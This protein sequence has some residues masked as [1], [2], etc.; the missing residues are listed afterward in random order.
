MINSAANKI[1][2]M[3]I[4]RNCFVTSYLL[5]SIFSFFSFILCALPFET[6]KFRGT[7]LEIAVQSDDYKWWLLITFI[8]SV[9]SIIIRFLDLFR[10]WPTL[11]EERLAHR[12]V[13]ISRSLEILVIA[14]PNFFLYLIISSNSNADFAIVANLQNALIHSQTVAVSGSIFCS[15]FGHKYKNMEEI[16]LDISIEKSTV[17]A[18][19]FL[20]VYK[21]F[22]FLGAFNLGNNATVACRI[23]AAIFVLIAALI[24]FITVL[25]FTHY[26]CQQLI[27]FT[28]SDSNQMHD[29]CRMVGVVGFCSYN[30]VF[31][32]LN[33]QLTS[34][35]AP[36]NQNSSCL[37]NF[38]IG[39]V[40]LIVY[41]TVIDQH[42]ALFDV[43]LK[44]EQLQMRLNLVRYISH[45]LRSPLNSSFLGLQMLRGN[46]DIIFDIIKTIRDH[47]IKNKSSDPGR[48]IL[49]NIARIADE[50]EGLNETIELV[51]ESSNIALETLNDMLTFDKIDEKKLK[52]EVEDTDVWKFVSDTVRPFRINAMKEQLSLTT[53]CTDL[54]SNWLQRFVIKA[55]K[56]KLNQV[57]RNFISN[58]LKFSPKK[59]GTVHVLVERVAVPSRVVNPFGSETCSHLINDIV[60]VSV[61]DNGFGISLENQ[62]ALFGQYVQFNA[63]AHQKGG[64]SGLGLW[65]SKRKR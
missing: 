63:S 43:T 37:V 34:S 51:K 38:L 59:T 12:H 45:E 50:K 19:I 36:Y 28:F 55:D 3:V 64:G 39:N 49:K 52:L 14:V 65:I 58:A 10:P 18:L 17:A 4:F 24:A 61:T 11:D 8:V 30:F 20:V 53:E 31:Y 48:I 27:G 54:E 42:C 47:V 62:K 1:L 6:N 9:P 26:L 32:A 16:Q 60:R 5:I 25:K 23:M 21:I 56:F 57:L 15:T 44:R 13:L 2:E 40:L 46:V 7:N 22:T 33:G 29:F 41:L 35:E